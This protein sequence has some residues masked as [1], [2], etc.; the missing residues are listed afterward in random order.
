MPIDPKKPINRFSWKRSR[1]AVFSRLHE[2]HFADTF[3]RTRSHII[4]HTLGVEIQDE[5]LKFISFRNN[6]LLLLILT[7]LS[8]LLLLTIQL[9]QAHF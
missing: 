2:I 5:V 7:S 8:S 3:S 9:K 4:S 1:S 6:P